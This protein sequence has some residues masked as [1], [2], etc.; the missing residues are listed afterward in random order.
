MTK[1]RVVVTGMG[2]ITPLGLNVNDTWNALL[3]GKSGIRPLTKI[4][5]SQLPVHFA[6][7]VEGFDASHY[8]NPKDARRLDTFIQYGMA[9]AKSP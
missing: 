9:A 4:D 3:A 2:M 8:M 7:T 1:R 5:V 6:G